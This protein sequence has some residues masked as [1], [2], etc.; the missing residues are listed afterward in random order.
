MGDNARNQVREILA[1]TRRRKTIWVAMQTAAREAVGAVTE[2]ARKRGVRSQNWLGGELHS[3]CLTVRFP[4]YGARLAA[5]TDDRS[6]GRRSPQATE[7]HQ[8]LLRG[9]GTLERP[10]RRTPY[11]GYPNLVPGDV[12][13]FRVAAVETLMA[14][15]NAH[16]AKYGRHGRRSR[17][18]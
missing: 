9:S 12:D 2:E 3:D 15:L 18:K 4:T 14:A 5:L 11:E 8:L 13:I 7:E 10:D 1:E 16:I 6:Y 17:R